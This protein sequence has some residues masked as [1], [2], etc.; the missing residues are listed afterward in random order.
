MINESPLFT[1]ALPI[2]EEI[3][4]ATV[5]LSPLFVTNDYRIFL[6]DYGY[7]YL[8]VGSLLLPRDANR[9]IRTRRILSI[10]PNHHHYQRSSR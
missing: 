1:K 2:I 5:K 9:I 8:L 4:Q 6:K 3:Q 7:S 10:S